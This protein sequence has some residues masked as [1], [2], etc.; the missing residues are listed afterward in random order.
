[1]TVRLIVASAAVALMGVLCAGCPG[2]EILA[3]D[4]PDPNGPRL[5]VRVRVKGLAH[6]AQHCRIEARYRGLLGVCGVPMAAGGDEEIVDCVIET[7]KPP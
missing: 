6:V 7:W 5:I 4:V 1:M 2:A 3:Y